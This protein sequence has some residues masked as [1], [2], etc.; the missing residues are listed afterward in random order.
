MKLENQVCTLEQAKILKDEFGLELDTYFAWHKSYIKS[1]E[2]PEG[3]VLYTLAD[4]VYDLEKGLIDNYYPA[5]SC[6]E[7]GKLLPLKIVGEDYW[8]TKDCIG[9]KD[10]YMN[11]YADL[12]IGGGVKQYEAPAK[13]DLLI[14]LFIGKN[15]KPED[16]TLKD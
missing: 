6:A 7:L 11:G 15:I 10:I 3:W 2:R 1:K 16:L 8:L 12:F 14:R 13:A 9:T 4:A 5:P